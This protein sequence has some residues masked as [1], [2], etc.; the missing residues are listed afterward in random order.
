M[1]I[2]H[3]DCFKIWD[4]N[5]DLEKTVCSEKEGI[6]IL[7]LIKSIPK[8]YLN[9]IIL[10]IKFYM[11]SINKKYMRSYQILSLL[12]YLNFDDT[13]LNIKLI[14]LL[15]P[16]ARDYWNILEVKGHSRIAVC[17]YNKI[18]DLYDSE[19]TYQNKIIG[20]DNVFSIPTELYNNYLV[21]LEENLREMELTLG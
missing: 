19:E 20:I 8:I 3:D 5:S 7:N 16:L 4:T 18:M 1:D 6:N 9:K 10:I 13:G 21:E 17:Y 11:E 2:S 14:H 15:Y 12:K